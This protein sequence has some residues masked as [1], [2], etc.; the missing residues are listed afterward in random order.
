M[1][2]SA[3][4]KRPKAKATP[5]VIKKKA[6]TELKAKAPVVEST[7]KDIFERWNQTSPL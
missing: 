3:P 5:K 2:R 4:K 7:E 1:A 6:S